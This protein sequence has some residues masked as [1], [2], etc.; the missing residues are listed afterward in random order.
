MVPPV[1]TVTL[2]VPVLAST[3][4]VT[5]PNPAAVPFVPFVPLVPGSPLSPL[6][7]LRFLKAKLKTFAVS[8]PDAVTVT[9]GVPVF[10]ST[11][12]VGVPNPAAVPWLP[13]DPFEPF[14]TVN[15]EVLPSLSLNV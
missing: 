10:A 7:P 2:G 6:A 15:V 8:A 9:L 4:A 5:L 3:D 1:V 11:D 13:C 12:A 14:L